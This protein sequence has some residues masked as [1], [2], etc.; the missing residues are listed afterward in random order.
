MK[1]LFEMSQFRYFSAWSKM[2]NRK[3]PPDL[4]LQE[5]RSGE[6]RKVFLFVESI[7]F[8][9]PTLARSGPFNNANR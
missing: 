5:A 4:F 1:N 2:S 6:P 9:E 7:D 3:M 8:K